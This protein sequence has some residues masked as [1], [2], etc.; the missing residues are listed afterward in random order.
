MDYNYTTNKEELTKLVNVVALSEGTTVLFVVANCS[1]SQT[2]SEEFK[3][4]LNT[5]QEEVTFRSVNC[6]EYS[7][8]EVLQSLDKEMRQRRMVLMVFGIDN[9][10]QSKY[11]KEIMQLN[12]SREAIFK[13]N[14]ILVFWLNQ[15]KFLN[16][17]RYKSPDFWDWQGGI[18]S[19]QNVSDND[20]IK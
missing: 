11:S 1:S 13:R 4:Q 2:V 3:T 10:P 16:E 17:F 15:E 14:L 20:K 18:F 19:F 7:L 8:Y 9:L 5:L 6:N 12:L